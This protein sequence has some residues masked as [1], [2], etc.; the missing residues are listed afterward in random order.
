[1]VGGGY[2]QVPQ[3]YASGLDIRFGKDVISVEIKSPEEKDQ[4][5]MDDA[6][7][8]VKVVCK[9]GSIFRADAVVI[10]T[11]LG[12]LKVRVHLYLFLTMRKGQAHSIQTAVTQ[13][14]NGC[15]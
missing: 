10:T 2:V 13:M 8:H 14:E 3:A 4:S 7:G 11:S 1:M 5:T 9:D 12:V 15:Y 6:L